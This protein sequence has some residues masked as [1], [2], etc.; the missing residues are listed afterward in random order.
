MEREN[1]DDWVLACRSF[2]VNGVRDRGRGR[3]NWDEC[4]TEEGLG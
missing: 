4:V 2:E 3:Q 1:S